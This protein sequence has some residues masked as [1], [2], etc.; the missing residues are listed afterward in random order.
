MIDR[1]SQLPP[2]GGSMA[3]RPLTEDYY[4]ERVAER[5][6]RLAVGPLRTAQRVLKARLRWAAEEPDVRPVMKFD[7]AIFHLR[8]CIDYLEELESGQG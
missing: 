5:Y 4:Q 2:E 7:L 8:Q 3:A 6:D 1:E